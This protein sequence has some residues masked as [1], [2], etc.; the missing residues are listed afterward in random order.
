VVVQQHQF[1][2]SGYRLKAIILVVLVRALRLTWRVRESGREILDDA[3]SGGGAVIAFWHGEQLPM[4]PLHASPRIAGLASKSADGELLAGVI[5][6]LGYGVLR[7]SS[8]RGG[9]SALRVA[10]AGLVQGVSPALAVDGPRGPRHTVQLGALGI[11]ARSRVPIV[12]VVSQVSWAWR[13]STWD[14]FQIP[15]PGATVRLS[16]GRMEPPGLERSA[17]EAGAVELGNRMETLASG[18]SS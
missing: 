1:P 4:V 11:A 17:L 18:L 15:L 7:G 12:Y 16:Y 6:L 2:T 13:L 5:H 9:A 8:S 10:A 14:R 3:V